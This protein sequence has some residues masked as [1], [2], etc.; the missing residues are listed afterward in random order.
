MPDKKTFWI[1]MTIVCLAAAPV[2]MAG[3]GGQQ[4]EAPAP[5]QP[6]TVEE[7]ATETPAAEAEEMEAEEAG[8]SEE[9]PAM[10][11]AEEEDAEEAAE[12][13]EGSVEDEAEEAAEEAEEIVEGLGEPVTDET[14][15]GSVWRCGPLTLDFQPEGALAV[16]G[17]DGGTWSI[18]GDKLTV[19][20]RGYTYVADIVEDKLYYGGEA[21]NLVKN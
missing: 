6:T 14:I 4:A 13:E 11:E 9:A 19:S 7:S 18:E 16:N 21:L 15:V 17:N 2:F 10:E 12:V 5:D 1:L 20:A 3:C 8:E